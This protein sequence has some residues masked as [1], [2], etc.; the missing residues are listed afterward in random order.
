LKD[1]VPKLKRA[2]KMTWKTGSRLKS[3]RRIGPRGLETM[4]KVRYELGID[5]IYEY[6]SE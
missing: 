5:K 6:L 1:V 4:R 3:I 2:K